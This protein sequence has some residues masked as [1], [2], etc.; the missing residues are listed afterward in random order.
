[1]KSQPVSASR[2]TAALHL[3]ILFSSFI[4]LCRSLLDCY[5]ELSAR[6][7]FVEITQS[8]RGFAKAIRFLHEWRDLACRHQVTEELQ[9]RLVHRG[10]ILCKL[11]VGEAR[12]QARTESTSDS[13]QLRSDRSG[14]P[15]PSQNADAVGIKDPAPFGHGVI[16]DVVEKQVVALRAFGEI[17]F[18]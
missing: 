18:R 4:R 13:C 3:R 6:V 7:T 2:M 10:R 12:P 16:V 14:A 15:N 5:D 11:A 8:L 1:M 17:F 9:V